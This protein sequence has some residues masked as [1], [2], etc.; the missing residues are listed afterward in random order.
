[1]GDAG[2]PHTA[3]PLG[4]GATHADDAAFCAMYRAQFD[5]VHATLRRLGVALRDIEDV[6]H[7]LFLAVH[8]RWADYHPDRPIRPWLFG[9]AFRV[10][11]DY[12]NRAGFR[13][14]MLDGTEPWTQA[15]DETIATDD[16]LIAEERR[17]LVL[18][19]L[20]E[21]DLE[22]RALFVMFEIDGASASEVAETFGIPPNTAY[23][24]LRLA[25]AEFEQAVRRL[26]SR[27]RGT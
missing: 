7:D 12:R 19:A 18:R 17:A 3:A 1:M 14:E 15:A 11:S 25:R 9:F 22:R 4:E 8:R 10:A 13:R 27:E 5:Y 24:R 26:S 21:L 16:R 6:A 20:Q 23:S 2:G